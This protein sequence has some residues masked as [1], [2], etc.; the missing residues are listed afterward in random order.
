M[1]P[2]TLNPNAN[3]FQPG[4]GGN[5]T[6]QIPQTSSTINAGTLGQNTPA[7]NLPATPTLS[8]VTNLANYSLEDIQNASN[9]PGQAQNAVTENT[10]SI[11]SLFQRITG[12]SADIQ[13]G[14]QQLGLQSM[15]KQLIDAK[16][17]FRT[18]TAE[19]NQLIQEAGV[20]PLQLQQ[21]ILDR[22]IT[23]KGGLAPI[24]A[25]KL[26][27]NAIK[28]YQVTSK[29]LFQQALIANLRDDIQG[30]KDAV[31]KAV[32]YKYAPLEQEL[33]FRSETLNSL[34]Q[35]DLTKEEKRRADTVQQNL[36]ERTRLLGIA[37]E[38]SK[39]ASAMALAAQKN[40]PNDKLAQYKAQ[41]AIREAQS[42]QPD[43][44]KVFQ[45]VGQYQ[46][47]PLDVEAQIANIEQSRASTR[48]SNASAAKSEAELK[49]INNPIGEEK[50][51]SGLST[52]AAGAVKQKVSSFK[53]EP[54]VTNFNVIN[55]GYN[56]VKSLPNDTENPSDDQALIYAFAKIM[57]PNSVVRE[58][59][60]STVQKYSQ[61]WVKAYGKGVEQAIAGTGILS[62]TARENMKKTLETKYQSSKK[63]YDNVYKQYVEGVNNITG[64]KDGNKF[65]TDY[66]KAFDTPTG[67]EQ[68]VGGITYVKGKD[69]LYYPKQ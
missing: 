39:T 68:T 46:T 49:A 18:T 53:T 52:Q 15:D 6:F 47:N 54:I 30:A 50:I 4:Q 32:D 19:Q 48:A 65:I 29:G 31:Q 43:L 69:G 1:N 20:I 56:T 21:D 27:E 44:S 26:R 9:T 34:L 35:S 11:K 3:Y 23:T 45:L 58:S 2:T 10:N 14:E 61:S 51:Y 28:Q 67:D 22:G 55:E 62:T 60:Y 24:Q 57:D 12:K 37:K 59:E 13:A 42:P 5:P 16:N 36:D 64:K 38:D 63:N 66:S 33:K 41:E 17:Q 25:G 7:I 40:F 8:P